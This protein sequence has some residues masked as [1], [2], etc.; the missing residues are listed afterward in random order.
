MSIELRLLIYS[1]VLL[2]VLVLVQALAGIRAQGLF[3]MAGHR[4]DLPPAKP[5]QGRTKRVVENHIEGL[6]MFAPL[7]LAA[8]IMGRMNETTELAA[9]LFFYSRVVHAFAYLIYIPFVRSIAWGVSMLA[10]I[11]MVLALLGV[12]A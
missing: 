9:R 10:T 12:L 8:A 5:Y 7:V 11:I 2:I 4:D 1:V 3:K 6:A